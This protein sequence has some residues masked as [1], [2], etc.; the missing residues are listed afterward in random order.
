MAFSHS[1]TNFDHCTL[2]PGIPAILQSLSKSAVVLSL[3]DREL[4]H[5]QPV[6]GLGIVEID[7]PRVIAGDSGASV[8]GL[9]AR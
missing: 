5:Y 8:W 3:D 4:V 2:S 1:L 7:Q 9:S 6:V